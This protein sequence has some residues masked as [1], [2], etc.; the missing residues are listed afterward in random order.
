MT[1]RQSIP[2][3][4]SALG[5]APATSA[6]PPDLANGAASLAAYKIVIS[7]ST[8]M[9]FDSKNRGTG[10]LYGLPVPLI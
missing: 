2:S 1:T 3:L 10:R 9:G 6:R 8:Q 7:T 5:S 4:T